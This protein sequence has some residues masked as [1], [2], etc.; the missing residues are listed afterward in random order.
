MEPRLQRRVQRY[1][2]DKAVGSY[3]CSWQRRLAPAQARL[4][5]RA[6]ARPGERV[7]DVACGTGL[8]S[9]PLAEAVSPAGHVLGTDLSQAMVEAA[10]ERA[11]AQAVAQASFECMGAEALALADGSF[12]LAV[13][14]LGLMYVP[15]TL[16]ALRELHRVLR[17]GGRAALLVWGARARCGWAEV[18]PIVDAR[19]AS[20]VCPLFFRLGGEGV[21]AGELAQAGF[22]EPAVERMRTTL[23]FA[24]DEDVRVAFME[25]G[26]VALAYDRFDGPTRRAVDA[27]YLASVA[28]YRNGRGYAIPAEFVL[29]TAFKEG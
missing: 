18:F 27:D 23:P 6:A 12:D 24:D 28:P 26:P 16:A 8:V 21:L 3:E 2:W 17:P 4:L 9:F 13:C 7:L 1:G 20:E 19:V 29:A 5:E 25:G 10:R 15:D 11:A 14:S 22:A